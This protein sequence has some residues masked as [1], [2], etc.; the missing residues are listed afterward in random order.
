M[1]EEQ[2]QTVPVFVHDIEGGSCDG[3]RQVAVAWQPNAED[4]Q[5]LNNGGLVYLSVIGGLPPHFLSTDFRDATNP[6]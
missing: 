1:T 6:A 3:F 5:K 2:V 4:L